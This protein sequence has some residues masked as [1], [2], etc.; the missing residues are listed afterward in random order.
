M[1]DARLPT[2]QLIQP[3]VPR[4]DTT[5]LDPLTR[6]AISE[7]LL[8][9][10][11]DEF[12]LGFCDSE[13]T[14]IAPM[15]EEDVA[16]SSLSQDEIGHARIWY[17]M[18]AQLTN[19]TA[20]HI[21]FGRPPEAYRHANLVDHPR[22]DWAFTIARRWLYETADSVRLAALSDA[23]WPPLTEIVAKIRR[24]EKYHLMHLDV[25][26]RRL[27]EGGDEARARLE[28]ALARLI[29]DA[30]SIFA[31][32]K[33]EE[34][35]VDA[36]VLAEPMSALARTWSVQANA[37]LSGLGFSFGELGQNSGGRDRSVPSDA[38]KW[39]WGEFTSVYRSEE[40]ATW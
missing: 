33:S 9:M 3:D 10:A 7:L 15:L 14:G 2:R 17:E 18:L 37:R 13:W 20:D 24:E 23:S 32:L 25:W 26:L 27:A 21:A 39:L 5:D 36:G 19:D 34:T 16:F 4:F 38:F 35:L 22:T 28:S 11:D 30:L 12:V 29:P 40:G 6:N 1:T 8:T 31:T